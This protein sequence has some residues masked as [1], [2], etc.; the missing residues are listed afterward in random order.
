MLIRWAEEKILAV[1]CGGHFEDTEV[2]VSWRQL[3]SWLD[4]V[5][6]KRTK[7]N[8][9]ATFFKL[10]EGTPLPLSLERSHDI[11]SMVTY[12][13]TAALPTTVP[14]QPYHYFQ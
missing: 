3:V 9:P 7:L 2:V 12:D 6:N 11:N 13:P 5:P 14:T 1:V 4:I 8:Q 10:V